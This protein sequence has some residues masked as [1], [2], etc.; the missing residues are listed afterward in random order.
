MHSN[1]QPC[2]RRIQFSTTPYVV[3]IQQKISGPSLEVLYQSKFICDQEKVQKLRDFLNSITDPIEILTKECS[4]EVASLDELQQILRSVLIALVEVERDRSRTNRPVYLNC[5]EVEN[6]KTQVAEVLESLTKRSQLMYEK[7]ILISELLQCVWSLVCRDNNTDY[8]LSTTY[9]LFSNKVPDLHYLL[10]HSIK[11][12]VQKDTFFTDN[13]MLGELSAMYATADFSPVELFSI[14]IEKFPKVAIHIKDLLKKQAVNMKVNPDVK[15]E[16]NTISFDNVSCFYCS[17]WP[18]IASE[19]KTRERQWPSDETNQKIF[20]AGCFIVAKQSQEGVDHSL[21]WRWSFSSAEIS[22]AGVRSPMMKYCYFVFKS[23]FYRY[24]KG[25][26]HQISL[27]SYVAKTCML[28]LSEQHQESWWELQTSSSGADQQNQNILRCV[29]ELFRFLEKCLKEQFLPHFFIAKLNLLADVPNEVIQQALE[30]VTN[31]LDRPAEMIK[32]DQETTKKIENIQEEVEQLW[33]ANKT[34]LESTTIASFRERYQ[35]TTKAYQELI[36]YL[37]IITRYSC[38][39]RYH[40]ILHKKEKYEEIKSC[41]PV[42]DKT[43]ATY[44]DRFVECKLA[45]I[46][47]PMLNQA[48]EELQS[49]RTQ[50]LNCLEQIARIRKVFC[51]LCNVCKEGFPCQADHYHCP[52]PSCD[53]DVCMSCY[54]QIGYNKLAVSNIGFKPMHEHSLLLTAE[55]SPRCYRTQF[56]EERSFGTAS[57][58][59]DVMQDYRSTIRMAEEAKTKIELELGFNNKRFYS[60]FHDQGKIMEEEMKKLL[61]N[62]GFE[63]EQLGK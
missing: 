31:I 22:L 48:L 47:H 63:D 13:G 32:F 4:L 57:N 39:L 3:S 62:L 9:N 28:Y 16:L 23:M 8:Y 46:S 42:F 29:I 37:A 59:H 54:D 30:S 50:A 45:N 21:E 25:A 52:E 49:T 26:E 7:Y 10:T 35:H 5:Q 2:K 33:K 18:E 6:M 34:T 56:T 20:Q 12:S 41:R 55:C 44:H 53:Y 1:L 38:L 27:P 43:D 61:K 58:W 24:F 19:W 17:F 36:R 60:I 51:K 11:Q 15:E 14:L 40:E